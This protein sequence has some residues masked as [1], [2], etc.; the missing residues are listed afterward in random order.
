MEVPLL[1]AEELRPVVEV[2]LLTAE[3][4][5]PV[6]EEPLL[7]AEELRPVVEVPLLT[8]DELRPVVEE[9]LLTADELRLEELLPT[10]DVLRAADAE[11]ERRAS[12]RPVAVR[13]AEDED[14]AS[15]LLPERRADDEATMLLFDARRF[16]LLETAIAL[17]EWILPLL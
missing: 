11:V 6:V 5:R 10:D 9:P 4:L 8:A 16:T 12:M 3:E 2:P 13:A 15:R 14:L 7:T 1:T 17:R